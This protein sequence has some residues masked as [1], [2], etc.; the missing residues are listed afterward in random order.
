MV[1]GPGIIGETGRRAKG[2]HLSHGAGG[3]ARAVK[4]TV[5]HQ[6]ICQKEAHIHLC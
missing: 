6:S 2:R 5:Y 1:G 3:H 4:P